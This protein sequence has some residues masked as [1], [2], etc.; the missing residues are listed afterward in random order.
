MLTGIPVFVNE[1]IKRRLNRWST[2]IHEKTLLNM[3][4]GKQ[5]QQENRFCVSTDG[6]SL[7]GSPALG[8][9]RMPGTPVL[10]GSNIIPPPRPAANGSRSPLPMENGSSSSFLIFLKENIIHVYA[11]SFCTLHFAKS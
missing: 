3:Y 7:L 2:L 4:N 8:S 10:S 5:C 11:C 9:G 6:G 1:T